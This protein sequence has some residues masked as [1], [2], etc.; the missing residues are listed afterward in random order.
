MFSLRYD[1][2]LFE[3]GNGTVKKSIHRNLQGLE[4][5][6]GVLGMEIRQGGWTRRRSQPPRDPPRTF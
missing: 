1:T 4:W 2:I 5:A 3:Y 6:F